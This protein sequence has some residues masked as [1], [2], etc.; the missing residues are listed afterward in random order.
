VAK[1]KESYTGAY[2]RDLLDRRAGARGIADL[3]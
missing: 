2:L 1:V 3:C